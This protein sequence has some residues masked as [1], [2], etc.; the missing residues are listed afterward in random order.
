VQISLDCLTLTDTSPSE[1]V[2]SA[3]EAGFDL[4]SLW[5]QPPAIYPK[6][7]LTPDQVRACKSQLSGSG[8]GVHSLEVFDLTSPEMLESYRPALEMGAELGGHAALTYQLTNPDCV[9]AA[10]VLA[11][12][13]EIAG[14]YGLA[15]NLEPVAMGQCAS[16]AQACDLI[17]ASRADVGIMFDPWHLVR[18]G[19]TIE[20]LRAVESG[21]IRYVQVNDGLLSIPKEQYVP[22]SIGERLYPGDGEFPLVDLLSLCPRDVPWAIECP[23]LRRASE[24][25]TPVQQAADAH[26][27]MKQLLHELG[28]LQP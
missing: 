14:E 21:R 15:V 22:E 6:A 12:F 27:A 25:F 2:G 28:I 18:S 19:G 13:T 1:V 9:Q 11:A 7:Q 16:L 4:V 3:A 8:L 26:S 23:S 5:V 10:E 20:D 17:A 24:G